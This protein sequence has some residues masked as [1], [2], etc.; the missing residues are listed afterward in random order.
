MLVNPALILVDTKELRYR[1]LKIRRDL[2]IIEPLQ[3]MLVAA[4][5]N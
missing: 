4:R 1:G 2:N 3:K 5:I